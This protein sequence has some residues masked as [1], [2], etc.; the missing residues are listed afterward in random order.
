MIQAVGQGVFWE[1]CVFLEHTPLF[2]GYSPVLWL[3]FIGCYQ[4]FMVHEKSTKGSWFIVG[5][6]D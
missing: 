4:I 6:Q 3:A 1:V 2:P 5:T